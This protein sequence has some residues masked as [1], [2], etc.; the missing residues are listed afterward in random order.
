MKQKKL[1]LTTVIEK[2][3]GEYILT[4][5]AYCRIRRRLVN[6]IVNYLHGYVCIVVGSSSIDAQK[7]SS[8]YHYQLV[9]FLELVAENAGVIVGGFCWTG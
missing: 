6:S 7:N 9:D 4:T 8:F 3:K 2:S 1:E 5:D